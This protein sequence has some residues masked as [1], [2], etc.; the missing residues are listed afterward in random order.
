M[1]TGRPEYKPTA[2]DR[3][4]V[5]AL[6]SYGVS[7]EDIARVVGV[8]RNTLRKHYVHQLETGAIKANAQV[9]RFLFVAAKRGSVPAM[10]FWLKCRSGWADPSA[11]T[12]A[13][14]KKEAAVAAAQQLDANSPFDSVIAARAERNANV[15]SQQ[16]ELGNRNSG[17][18]IADTRAAA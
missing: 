17:W 18:P 11:A 10:M 16:P 1:R 5:D 7:E 14:G 15:G 9:A 3:A 4:Y 8:S 13:Q 2:K 12:A 6:A